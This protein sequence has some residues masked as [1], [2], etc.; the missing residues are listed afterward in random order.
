[1][2]FHLFK[3]RSTVIIRRLFSSNNH[4]AVATCVW[5]IFQGK[6][7]N[8]FPRKVFHEKWWMLYSRMMDYIHIY[9]YIYIYICCSYIYMYITGPP[10]GRRRVTL[11]TGQFP[12]F[13]NPDF[14]LKNVD[15]ILKNV[16]FILKNVDFLLKDL[17]KSW[18]VDFII[19][20]D[21]WRW[22]RLSCSRAPDTQPT[23]HRWSNISS[24]L[25]AEFIIWIEIF[26]INVKQ[27]WSCAG[28][29]KTRNCVSKNEEFCITNDDKWWQMMTFP[30]DRR[31][32]PIDMVS[33]QLKNQLKNQLIF[34][35][36]ML[37]L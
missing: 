4:V 37:I 10:T 9:M 2:I 16:D 11:S 35:W 29:V 17:E 22:A 24:F 18:N 13:K 30:A 20:Q 32:I 26:D 27:F 12:I 8:V 14:L 5:T 7:W 6:W 1:M 19:N 25:N 33:F 23:D 3:N 36:K 15:F 21:R 31:R 34:C 28:R